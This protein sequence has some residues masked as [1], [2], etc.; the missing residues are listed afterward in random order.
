MTGLKLFRNGTTSQLVGQR[1]EAVAIYLHLPNRNPCTRR[2]GAWDFRWEAACELNVSRMS[3]FAQYAKGPGSKNLDSC[4][5]VV[6]CSCSITLINLHRGRGVRV[7]KP[8]AQG[9]HHASHPSIDC[10]QRF[11]P[12]KIPPNAP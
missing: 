11:S 2:D 6:I 8:A 3:V 12:L 7:L 9:Q 1:G 5:C 4:R 10:T